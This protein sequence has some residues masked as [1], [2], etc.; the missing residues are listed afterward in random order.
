MRMILAL[1]RSAYS[2][3]SEV[4][5]LVGDE[6]ASICL[7]AVQGAHKGLNVWATYGPVRCI[8]LGLNVDAL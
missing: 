6:H 3:A 1:T 2:R 7:L 4:N 8:A 5:R